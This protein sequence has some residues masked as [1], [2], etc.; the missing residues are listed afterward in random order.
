MPY[1]FT[2]F[3][4][5][6]LCSAFF[7]SFIPLKFSLI[8]IICSVLGCVGFCVFGRKYFRT[9][10]FFASAAIGFS[11]VLANVLF[12]FNPSLGLD[13][14]SA[15]ISGT[16]TEVSA[17]GGNPVYTIKTDSV[18]VEGAPQKIKVLVSGWDENFAE[19]YDKVSCEV[20]FRIYENENLSNV[21][22]NHSGKIS[23]HAYTNSPIK[24]I[25]EEHS[26]FGYF[27]HLIREKISSVIYRFFIDWHAPFL[28]Q[29]LIGTRGEL[30]NEIITAFRRSGM[31]H[32][33][34]I[35]G[36]HMVII[37]DLIRNL[38]KTFFRGK[39]Y[40]V[41]ESVL[42]IVFI[43][44]YMFVG[45]FGM[46]VRRSAFMLIISYFSRLLFSGSKS[47]ENLG[48]AVVAVLLTSPMAACD[49]GFLMSVSA[50]GAI[51]FFVPPLKKYFS[52]RL[53]TGE[54]RFANYVIQAFCVSVVS[55]LAV[56]PVSALVFG[57]VSVVSPVSNIFAGFFAQ[58]TI[59]FGIIT[60]LLG[61][62]PFL[63]FAAGFTAA[64]S[65]LCADVL[66]AIADFFAGFSFSYIDASD[67]WFYIWI[68]GS[69]VLIIFPIVFSKSFRFAKH[70]VIM[71][72]ALLFAG[73]ICS[74]IAFSGV[75]EIKISAF[76]HGTAISCS[77]DKDSMLITNGV[78]AGEIF[79]YDFPE[80]GYNYVISFNPESDSAEFAVVDSSKPEVAFLSTEDCIERF[81]FAKEISKESFSFSEG[82][83]AKIF[84]DSA[85]AFEINGVTVLYIFEE[86]DIMDIEPK[87]RRADIIILDGVSPEFFPALRCD[88]LILREKGGY[89]SGTNEIITLKNG[90]A[91]FFAHG[92]NLTKGSADR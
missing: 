80:S 58:Y 36:M 11:L 28:E 33:L 46:S 87:F 81:D 60:V 1:F 57:K 89:Y 83:A 72:A 51:S 62:V 77:K 40:L 13:G 5:I 88:Y 92:G 48:I 20:T 55:F 69:A 63:G 25:G 21:L 30:E 42:M 16:V 10:A 74:N 35:S 47:I 49:V 2:V 66:L 17:S 68:L 27:I 67:N 14:I 53:K 50:C 26:S 6:M 91:V 73:I 76:E 61:M 54:N 32:I 70:S 7:A 84:P 38:F 79:Y 18:Y 44:I 8:L 71:S 19:V 45:G 23:I 65:S 4:I 41:T 22:A 3:A 34:A 12:V 90:E 52:E 78:S 64:I 39:K 85:V 56:L 24:V 29:L 37:S 31:S 15:E 9:A 75:A 86:C 82:S 43:F 59:I